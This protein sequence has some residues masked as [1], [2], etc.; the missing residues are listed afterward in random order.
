MRVTPVG[1]E[2][3]FDVLFAEFADSA[4][5]CEHQETIS[6][7]AMVAKKLAATAESTAQVLGGGPPSNDVSRAAPPPARASDRYVTLAFQE[8]TD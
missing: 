1:V 7:F 3:G 4:S 6:S 2:V 8:A 5:R